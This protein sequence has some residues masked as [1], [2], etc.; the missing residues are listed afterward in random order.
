MSTE[1]LNIV[2]NSTISNI[3]QVD[4]NDNE[5]NLSSSDDDV[6][7]IDGSMTE[8]E[9]EDEIEPDATPIELSPKSKPNN[10]KLRVLKASSLPLVTLMNAR[11]VY[12]KAD[13]FKQFMNELGIEVGIISETWEREDLSLEDLLK[14]NNYQIHSYKRP[15]VKARKQPGGGSAIVYNEQRFKVQKLD[16]FVKRVWKPAGLF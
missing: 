10:R 16:V 4:G 9:T 11:S 2:N 14:M 12:N 1:K 6:S 7:D 15:K 8:Y 3:V 13:N 5:D